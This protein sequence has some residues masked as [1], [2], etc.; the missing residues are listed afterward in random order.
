MSNIEKNIPRVGIGVLIQNDKEEFLL[1]LRTGSHGVGEW[2]F[3]GGWLDYGEKIFDC[4]KREVKEEVGLDVEIVR[5]FSIADQMRYM[6][7]NGFHVVNIG[8]LAKYLGGE[9]QLVEPDKFQ[10]WGWFTLD[11]LPK[12]LFEGTELQL[13]SLESGKVDFNLR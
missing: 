13:K 1:G 5:A 9:P 6:G 2:C 12:P 4:G 3:P 10:E 7:S 11:N 8:L